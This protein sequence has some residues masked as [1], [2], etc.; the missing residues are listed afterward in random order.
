MNERQIKRQAGYVEVA[1]FA[2]AGAGY[3]CG[4]CWKFDPQGGTQG[5]CVGLK[6]P[7]RSYGC[8]NYWELE[9]DEPI[10]ANGRRLPVIR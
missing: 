5:Y 6:V 3:F 8:C 10:G 1:A 2:S 9:A 4:T 7:V